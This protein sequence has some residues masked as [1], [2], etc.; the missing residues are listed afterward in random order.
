MKILRLCKFI[1]FLKSLTLI[2]IYEVTIERRYADIR[3]TGGMAP[4]STIL[5][6][7]QTSIQRYPIMQLHA[8]VPMPNT[9]P[10]QPQ[11]SRVT[12][13]QCQYRTS[14]SRTILACG[15]ATI[16][17]DRDD[18][19]ETTTTPTTNNYR[20][21]SAGT[22]HHETHSPIEKAS[23]SICTQG[24]DGKLT[25]RFIKKPH[26]QVIIPNEILTQSR[27]S[28]LS[29]DNSKIHSCYWKST[30][31]SSLTN[32]YGTWRSRNG[33]V[34]GGAKTYKRGMTAP[35]SKSTPTASNHHTGSAG[36]THLGA[37]LPAGNHSW[38][39]FNNRRWRRVNQCTWR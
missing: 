18:S 8:L 22:K 35:E 19:A 21:G 7:I 33:L 11:W 38:R 27:R 5:S 12:Q 13:L 1:P 9:I 2:S 26:V 15:G 17:Q 10:T 31:E 32:Q 37:D 30:S 34:I 4:P 28:R 25:Y 36:R 23:S 20:T 3:C 16:I 6:T 39:L 24:S 29:L 14:W